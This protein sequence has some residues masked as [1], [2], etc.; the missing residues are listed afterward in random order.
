MAIFDHEGNVCSY[1]V[2]R[3]DCTCVTAETRRFSTARLARGLIG[4]YN[5]R[6]H[7]DSTVPPYSVTARIVVGV[8][9]TGRGALR[10][11]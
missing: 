2:D 8:Q 4:A 9:G 1:V 10:S 6:P 3:V 7:G 5:E 11:T